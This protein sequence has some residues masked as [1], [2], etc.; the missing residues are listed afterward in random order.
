MGLPP[1]T[2]PPVNRLPP[3]KHIVKRP[4]PVPLLKYADSMK[5]FQTNCLWARDLVNSR[6]IIPCCADKMF[7]DGFVPMRSGG[8]DD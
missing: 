8:M 3:E 2:L 1:I 7:H 6:L 5:K 4:D